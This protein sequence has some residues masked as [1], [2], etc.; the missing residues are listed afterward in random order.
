M[1]TEVRLLSSQPIRA[2]GCIV[3]LLAFALACVATPAAAAPG[4]MDPEDAGI[5][6]VID[7]FL[8]LLGRNAP[9]RDP[10]LGP[11]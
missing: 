9:W 5:Q 10:D 4:P 1:S 7:S 6:N 2:T 3:F 11:D 8:E